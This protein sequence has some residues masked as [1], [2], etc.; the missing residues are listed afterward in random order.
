M[1]KKGQYIVYS[2]TGVCHVTDIIREAFSGDEKKEYYVLEPIQG[3]GSTI[4]IPT[5][6][7]TANIRDI[8]TKEEIFSLIETMPDFDSDW[9][10]DD[11]VRK[12]KF[13]EVLKESKPHELA[14]LIKTLYA[15]QTELE[16]DGKTLSSSDTETLKTAKQVLHNEIAQVMN[17]ELDQVVP[18]I[19]GQIKVS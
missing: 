1:L 14:R 6:N 10:L 11:Q 7:T 2:S 13:V 3:N 17:L 16:K 8:M 12:A 18:F 5:D 9:N 19:M 15:R 4:Y